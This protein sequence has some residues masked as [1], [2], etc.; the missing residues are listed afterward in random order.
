MEMIL[1]PS[2]I[3]F[4]VCVFLY[5]MRKKRLIIAEATA[6]SKLARLGLYETLEVRSKGFFK[7]K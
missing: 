4:I 7:W 1:L 6:F 5:F 3:L 2:V